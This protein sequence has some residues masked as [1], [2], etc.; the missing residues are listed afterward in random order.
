MQ[1]SI[2]FLSPVVFLQVKSYLYFSIYLNYNTN[3]IT[4][5][6][7]VKTMA[8]LN[9]ILTESF[10]FIEVKTMACLNNILTESFQFIDVF[11]T[12]IHTAHITVVGHV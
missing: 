10:Q 5:C 6:V 4:S 1:L 8:C 7:E 11:Y 3:H 2:L 12:S 9:N